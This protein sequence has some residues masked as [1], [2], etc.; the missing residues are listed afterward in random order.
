M[1]SEG[2][3]TSGDLHLQTGS[4]PSSGGKIVECCNRQGPH[5]HYVP[6]KPVV[7]AAGDVDSFDAS[8]QPNWNQLDDKMES[9]PFE[10]EEFNE[11]IPVEDQISEDEVLVDETEIVEEEDERETT[12]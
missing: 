12:E 3:T 11:V 4:E 10:D 5:V 9:A 1:S 7:N 8:N 2:I 6:K